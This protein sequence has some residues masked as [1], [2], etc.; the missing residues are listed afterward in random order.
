YLS[1]TTLFR[2]FDRE[3]GKP[4]YDINEMQV[5]KSPIQEEE[6]WPTQPIP[7][8]P[9]T[10]SRLSISESELNTY[11]PDYDSLRQVFNQ[12]NKGLYQPFSE[13]PTFIVP[14]LN[15]GAEWGGAAVDPDGILYVNSNEV[16]WIVTLMRN[17]NIA[18][19]SIGH[20]VYVKNC[21]SCHGVDRTGNPASGFPTL[22]ALEKRF[23]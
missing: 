8:A 21:S 9:A 16:P 2:S 11:S 23:K 22:I 14:G 5:P 20:S 17:S 10:V 12:T 13:I 18:G 3:T 6:A 7:S 15:G 1:Y 4:V 19:M